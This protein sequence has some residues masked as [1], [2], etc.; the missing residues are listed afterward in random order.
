MAV[1]GDTRIDVQLGDDEQLVD[2]TGV[3]MAKESGAPLAGVYVSLK[4]DAGTAP[5]SLATA[6]FTDARG[7]FSV[8]LTPGRYLLFAHQTGFVPVWRHQQ[9]SRT[10]ANVAIEMATASGPLVRLTDAQTGQP[11]PIVA[12][13]IH[14]APGGVPLRLTQA[15][16]APLWRG[17]VGRDLLFRHPDY[18]EVRVPAWNGDALE[19]KMVAAGSTDRDAGR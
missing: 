12:L 11:L 15:G 16:T 13:G 9:I 19:L 18:E 4:R 7:A 2:Y 1:A 17:L 8:P 5:P 3:I 14:G 10:N 6:R